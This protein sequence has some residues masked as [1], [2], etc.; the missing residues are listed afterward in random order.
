MFFPNVK[1][2]K[3]SKILNK[4]HFIEAEMIEIGANLRMYL[5]KL[6][7]SSALCH[8]HRNISGEVLAE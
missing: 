6:L 3:R 2:W 1:P 8:L 4:I 5:R 7:S